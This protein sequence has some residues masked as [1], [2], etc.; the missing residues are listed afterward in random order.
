M[1][2]EIHPSQCKQDD[3]LQ[4][5]L[6]C[7]CSRSPLQVWELVDKPFGKTVIKLK[8]LWK[9]KKDEDQTEIYNKARLVTKGYAHE[10]DIDSK[11]S[12]ALVTRLFKRNSYKVWIQRAFMLLFGQDVKTFNNTMLLFVEQLKKQ[13]DKDEFQEYE[14]LAAF[15]MKEGEV[16]RGKSLDVEVVVTKSSGTESEK[17]DTSNR[18][19]KETHAKDVDIKLVNDKEPMAEVQMAAEYNVLTNGQHH[20]EKPEFNNE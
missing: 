15:W 19:G 11:E 18:S 5:I 2:I 6:K 8:W 4:Q 20:A 10:E 13:L 17:L 12:F 3:N 1:F 7:V 16:N 9:N 14:S